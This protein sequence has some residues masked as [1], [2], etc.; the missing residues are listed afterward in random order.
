[1]PIS[2]KSSSS[3]ALTAQSKGAKAA[4]AAP[5]VAKRA[6]RLATAVDRMLEG[7]SVPAAIGLSPSSRKR[8]RNE[9]KREAEVAI[10]AASA[11]KRKA[12]ELR[13]SVRILDEETHQKMMSAWNKIMEIRRNGKPLGKSS[14]FG[15]NGKLSISKVAVH[16]GVNRINL[17]RAVLAGG[18]NRPGRPPNVTDVDIQV[19]HT[20]ATVA[21]LQ[22]DAL[23]TIALEGLQHAAT[24]RGK[25]FKTRSKGKV[26]APSTERRLSS[27]IKAAGIIKT[28]GIQ[29]DNKRL[30]VSRSTLESHADEICKLVKKYP[31]LKNRKAWVNVDETPNCERGE[32]QGR[33]CWV[34]TT[35]TAMKAK[36]GRAV[37]SRAIGNG[38]GPL[39][40]VP[41]LRGDGVVVSTAFLSTGEC[42]NPPLYGGELLPGLGNPFAD[43]VTCRIFATKSGSMTQEVLEA[44][45]TQMVIPAMRR[46]VPTGPL[47]IVMDAPSCHGRTTELRTFLSRHGVKLLLL[48]HNSSTLTQMLDI[49]W[50]LNWRDEYQA[51]ADALLEVSKSAHARLGPNMRVSHSK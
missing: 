43:P 39:S 31:S 29:T 38:N 41:A 45:L 20:A 40:F 36:R 49:G 15:T 5:N 13:D 25:A 26:V 32:K 51:T 9:S 18:V 46:D 34:L 16:F 37:R 42:A 6:S 27:R 28:V 33:Q 2:K 8:A 3:A 50:F 30:K 7:D 19:L 22:D 48:P 21:S 17:N 47:V 12:E 10:E 24:R 23:K 11:A 35:R 1:M 4:A 44:F 14:A